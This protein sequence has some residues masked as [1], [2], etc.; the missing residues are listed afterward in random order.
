VNFPTI[1]AHQGLVLSGL[2]AAGG[3]GLLARA[4]CPVLVTGAPRRQF[5]KYESALTRELRF[6]RSGVTARQFIVIQI[7]LLLGTV[8]LFSSG[9]ILGI[10]PLGLAILLPVLLKN[11][12]QK[13]TAQLEKQI[14]GW[15]TS[16]ARSLEAAPSLGEALD[17]SISTCDAP[18]REE[19]EQL[20]NE[21][22]LGRPIDQALAEWSERVGSRVLTMAVATLLVG[23][24]TGGQIGE[25]LR[26]AA[27]SLREMER[28][29]GVIRTKT[30]EGK[31][32][33]WVISIVPFPL[34]FGVKASD[35]TFFA[36]L[37]QTATGHL[38]LAICA[39]LWIGAILSARKILAVQI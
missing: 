32:Q 30:A 19:I 36:P 8:A 23:R 3:A 5:G 7:V 25:V 4:L 38:L 34:Y 37:E 17:A 2:L 24:E 1:S 14:E 35:P 10:L 18:M 31:G 11:A 13:R 29:E 27:A 33:A 9:T 28:L 39:A 15:L 6:V 21:I 20:D 22:R 16:V 26:S 12:R